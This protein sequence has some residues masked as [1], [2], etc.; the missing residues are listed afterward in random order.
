MHPN[1]SNFFVSR[2]RHITRAG[3]VLAVLILAAIIGIFYQSY[4]KPPA[5]FPTGTVIEIPQGQNLDQ[6][7][8]TLEAEHVIRSAFWF[9]NFVYLFNGE[10]QIVNGDYYLGTPSNSFQMARRVTSGDFQ[11]SQVKT[12]IPEG[13]TVFQI[14]LILEKRYPFFDTVHFL[15]LAQNKEG[16]LFPDTYKFGA[17]VDPEE[18]IDVMSQNFN[19][20]IEEASTS[21]TIAAFGKPVS[22]VIVMAS[23]LE[24]EA[25]QTETRQ[26][27]A[28][29]LWH[30]LALGMPLDLDST[31][32]Y[33]TGKTSAEMTTSDL[34]LDSPY[35]TYV[36]K[37]LPP[38]PINNPGLDSILAAVTPIKSN[39]L[40][41]LSDNNGVMH[42]ATTLAGQDANKAEYLDQ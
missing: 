33:V 1:F 31:L 25:R 19:E 39:Y 21:A 15:T 11:V 18:V 16:Y 30:R 40:Y 7:A 3:L 42:Y 37:G 34:K 5:D 9:E 28:G 10:R 8:T 41:F 23:L 22:D 6:T 38:T 20:K 36:H 29:I 4:L 12:T 14:S 2:S 24:A 27:I 13:S 32:R 35:N 17:E 26:M